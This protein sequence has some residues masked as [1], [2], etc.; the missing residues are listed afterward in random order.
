M[1]QR[2]H[3]ICSLLPRARSDRIRKALRLRIFWPTWGIPSCRG[4]GSKATPEKCL[5]RLVPVTTPIPTIIIGIWVISIRICIIWIWSGIGVNGRR[6]YWTN[7]Y[8]TSRKK[9]Q[10][11]QHP[12]YFF[13]WQS[14]FILWKTLFVSLAPFPPQILEP[15]ILR[16][17]SLIFSS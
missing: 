7:G 3:S 6:W 4:L 8:S 5:S 13:H 15:V 1:K 2:C 14:P 17:K 10:Q 12:N 16:T 11:K 9:T